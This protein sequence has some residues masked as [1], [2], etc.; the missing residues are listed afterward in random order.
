M[1]VPEARKLLTKKEMD[2]VTEKALAK[3]PFSIQNVRRIGSQL[4]VTVRY[5][6]QENRTQTI[7]I[8]A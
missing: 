8:G 1:T 6:R 3:G 2:A 4:E 7:I 5:T